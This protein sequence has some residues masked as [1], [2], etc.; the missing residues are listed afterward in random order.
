MTGTTQT[1]HELSFAQLRQLL[2]GELSIRQLIQEQLASPATIVRWAVVGAVGYVVYQGLL[3]LVYDS[4]LFPFLADKDTSV[5]LVL[6]EHGDSRFLIATLV[7]TAFG[8]V[9]IFTGHNLWTFRDRQPVR[10]H[11]M[12]RFAQFV[13]TALISAL[14]IVA[15]TVNVLTVQFNFYHFLALP[16]AVGLGAIWDW[17]W[18]SQFVWRRAGH[19]Q[20]DA[21]R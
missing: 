15:V 8:L 12:L 11:V 4:P 3:F 14:G 19:Q 9:S 20:A 18:Y 7:A 1:R 13:A 6:F 16:I 21:H 10:K 17:L 2:R 5:S